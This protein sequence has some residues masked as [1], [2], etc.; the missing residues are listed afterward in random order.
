MKKKLIAFVLASLLVAIGSSALA[1]RFGDSCSDNPPAEVMSFIEE[2][3]A[4]WELEDY[5]LIDGTLKG[6]YGFAMV[7]SGSD[8]VLLGFH[9]NGTQMKYWMKN[10]DAVPQGKGWVRFEHI[11][12]STVISWGNSSATYQDSLGFSLFRIEF[13]REEYWSQ[14]VAYHYENGAFKLVDYMDHDTWSGSAYVTDSGISYYDSNTETRPGTV[15]GTVQR[16]V[17]YVSFSSLPKTYEKAK[18]KLTVA[19]ENPSGELQ[20]QKIKFTGG[21]KYAVYSAPASTSLRSASGKALVSTND[22]IQVFGEEDGYILIQYAVSSDHMRFGY[23]SADALPGSASVHPLTWQNE[24][25]YVTEDTELTDDPLYSRTSSLS[26]RKDAVVTLLGYMG[27]WAY[28]ETDA[29]DWARGFLPSGVLAFNQVYDL[30]T[31]SGG[32]VSGTLTASP[33]Q[34]VL[35]DITVNT[36]VIPEYFIL[37]NEAGQEIG[38]VAPPVAEMPSCYQMQGALPAGTTAIRFI[39]VYG[40]YASKEDMFTVTL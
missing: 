27:E 31:A 30:K 2:K 26:L 24:K 11:N 25:A 7:S 20:G 6:D 23:I 38:R 8:R 36:E 1:E 14:E 33:D 18:E 40:G 39:P 32:A 5:I 37:T 13:D 34:Q 10:A 4:G 29:G 21:K 19:P 28:V 35:V 22:W 16:D 9:S 15:K 3:Y 12:A 17:R